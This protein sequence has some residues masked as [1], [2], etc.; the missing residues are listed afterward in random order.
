MLIQVLSAFITVTGF[1]DF[2]VAQFSSVPSV[3][4]GS[5]FLFILFRDA[6]FA[7]QA[8]VL[9]FLTNAFLPAFKGHKVK[10]KNY[11]P[12]FKKIYL[13]IIGVALLLVVPTVGSLLS[14]FV[15]NYEALQ[16]TLS[17]ITMVFSIM[18]FRYF[19]FYIEL[20]AGCPLFT[21][22]KS[23]SVATKGNFFG[24]ALVIIAAML[25]NLFILFSVNFFGT[26][27]SIFILFTLP[28]TALVFAN[29]YSQLTKSTS[30]DFSQRKAL[31]IEDEIMEGTEK[32]LI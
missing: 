10:L 18:L 16:L 5:L 12:E 14:T 23:S 21:S 27:I 3:S 26:I 4:K 9:L 7:L 29:V 32:E 24:I 2:S 25:T 30:E 13:F 15:P 22:F 6:L 19:F 11:F 31:R 8:L 1:K 17:A 28:M 20:L